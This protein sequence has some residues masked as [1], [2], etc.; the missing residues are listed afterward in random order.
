MIKNIFYTVAVALLLVTGQANAQN[1]LNNPTQQNNLNLSS[2]FQ[3][4]TWTPVISGL[5]T[6]NAS[7]PT[8]N[9]PGAFNYQYQIGTYEVIGRQV[10]ARFNVSTTGIT[11][12]SPG[13]IIGITGLPFVA[14]TAGTPTPDYG[15]CQIEIY[16][17]MNF[18]SGY[19]SLAGIITPGTSVIGITESGSG[20]T[21]AMLGGLNAGVIGIASTPTQIMGICSYHSP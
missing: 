13:G 16:N 11:T 17:G 10:T 9:T 15:Q 18:D 4:G 3:Q 8:N 21:L 2:P 20:K 12:S 19:S 14:T 1:N 7:T 6:S 5:P